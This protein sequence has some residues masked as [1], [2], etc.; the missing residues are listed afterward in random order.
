MG[1][2]YG[3]KY[4]PGIYKTE[5]LNFIKKCLGEEKFSRLLGSKQS[6]D[7]P[8]VAA[9]L[10]LTVQDWNRYVWIE[11]HGSLDGFEGENKSIS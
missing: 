1:A 9:K 4:S 11:H 8:Y 6:R 2:E 10:F 5:S 3:V 7:K